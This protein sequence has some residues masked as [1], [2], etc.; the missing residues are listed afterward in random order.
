MPDLG[1]EIYAILDRPKRIWA[2][3]A[4]HGAAQ[5][6]RELHQQLEE[7]FDVG[8]RL[9]YLGNFLGHG[10]DIV[11]TVDELITF[12]SYALTIPGIEPWD[13]VFLR[14]AQE[15]MWHKLLQLQFAQ[16][17][18]EVLDWM[19]AQGVAAT[20]AAYGGNE[21]QGLSACR[22]G[23]LAITRWTNGLRSAVHARDGHDELFA[24]LR[25]YAVSDARSLLFVSAGVD[26]GRPL[27]EQAD[28]FWWGGRYFDGMT[29]AYDDFSKVI[30]G[31]DSEHAGILDETHRLSIDDGAGFGGRLVAAC[32]APD[33]TLNEIL[34][35]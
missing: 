15:E 34:E 1:N 18:G 7:R 26:S 22:E 24:C 10:T 23:V 19:L 16:N 3:A 5:Q 29:A 14:G 28:T 30:R 31:Y 35:A 17:P 6:L 13:V 27:S 21:E 20:L 11:E 32:L 9:V 12:R 2:V 4:V 25:R 33:G 8:D